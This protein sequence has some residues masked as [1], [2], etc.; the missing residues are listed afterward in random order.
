MAGLRRSP[1]LFLV[2]LM[3]LLLLGKLDAGTFEGLQAR[4]CLQSQLLGA[5]K[6]SADGRFSLS[7]R[8]QNEYKIFG[9]SLT[10]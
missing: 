5:K 8:V 10:L 7:L 1:A 3:K 9:Y 2:G 4:G 6:L